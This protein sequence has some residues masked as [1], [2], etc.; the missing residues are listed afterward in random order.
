MVPLEGK[1]R[2]IKFVYSFRKLLILFSF[3]IMAL[4]YIS[5]INVCLYVQVSNTSIEFRNFLLQRRGHQLEPDLSEEVSARLRLGSGSNGLL[6]RKISI[7]ETKEKNCS[8]KEKDKRT[9]DL[10]ELTEVL[11]LV[12]IRIRD[13]FLNKLTY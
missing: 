4:F 10:L 2:Y 11:F 5:C 8:G 13:M 9:D 1:G 6:R 3:K 7:L 12:L